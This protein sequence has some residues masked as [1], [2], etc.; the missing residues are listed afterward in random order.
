MSGMFAPLSRRSF[1]N[2]TLGSA[3]CAGLGGL[4]S[5]SATAADR[6]AGISSTRLDDKLTLLAGGGGNVVSLA[7]AEGLL[8]V[9]GGS[10]ERSAELLRTLAAEFPGRP[11]RTLLNTHWHWDHTGSNDALAANGAM[12]V[13]HQNTKLWLGTRVISQ[14]EGRTYPPRRASALPRRTFFYDSERLDVGGDAVEYGHLVQAHTDGDIY[15]HFPGH[16]VLAGGDVVAG[17]RYPVIDYS[18]GGW[19]GGMIAGLR[20]LIAK[21]DHETRVVPGEGPLRSRADLEA[22][23]EMCRAV[24]TRIAASYFRGE[25]W[26]EFAASKPTRDF[27]ATWGTPDLFLRTA[28][29]SAWWH[30]NEMRRGSF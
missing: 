9:D 18:T 26:K 7:Y 23:L 27:D 24:A 14:W 17:G 8:L 12:I 20:T 13:A 22:Q 6:P 28:H 2:A 25:T 3:A 21:C 11:I 29:A 30:I 10:Q 5:R 16:N 4:T 15:V 1:L 19:I